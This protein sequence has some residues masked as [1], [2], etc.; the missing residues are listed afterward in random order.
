MKRS[1]V[2]ITAG[3][4]M[5]FFVAGLAAV[6]AGMAAQASDAGSGP[7]AKEAKK[8][9]LV[10]DAHLK[11]SGEKGATLIENGQAA[12]TYAAPMTAE[13]TLHQEPHK[14][15][16]AVAVKIYPKG[17]SITGSA[18]AEYRT[19]GALY[20]FGGLLTLGRGTGKYAHVSEVSGKALGFSGIFNHRTLNAEE[21]KAKGEIIVGS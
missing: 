9:E 17:G 18:R 19:V 12:G 6:T 21:V 16:V 3:L 11:F 15:Y 8:V 14:E 20:Y 4:L 2:S 10:E 1:G 13:L 5:A 7:I